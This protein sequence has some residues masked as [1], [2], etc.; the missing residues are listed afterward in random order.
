MDRVDLILD[1]VRLRLVLVA[2]TFETNAMEISTDIEDSAQM[3][4]LNDMQ[5]RLAAAHLQ[6]GKALNRLCDHHDLKGAPRASVN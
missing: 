6:Y 4:L 5:R 1:L 3:A 2:A